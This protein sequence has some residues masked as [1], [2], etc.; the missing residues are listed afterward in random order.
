METSIC[1]F[2]DL[3]RT[4]AWSSIIPVKLLSPTF[5][6]FLAKKSFGGPP[7]STFLKRQIMFHTGTAFWGSPPPKPRNTTLTSFL[8]VVFCQVRYSGARQQG[9]VWW[10]FGYVWLNFGPCVF[11]RVSLN[12]YVLLV[13]SWIGWE[14]FGRDASIGIKMSIFLCVAKRF[15]AARLTSA[16]IVSAQDLIWLR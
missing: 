1:V 4:S 5:I 13:A 7:K 14:V 6:H 3:L 16:G 9:S 15:L 11:D 10:I 8:H 2:Q 12:Q